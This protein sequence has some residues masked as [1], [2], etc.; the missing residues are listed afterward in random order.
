MFFASSQITIAAMKY[1]FIIFLMYALTY[2]SALTF[3]YTLLILYAYFFLLFK[4]LLLCHVPAGIPP[5]S[6]IPIQNA[7]FFYYK[8]FQ[9]TRKHLFL[10]LPGSHIFFS[11][12]FLSSWM[13]KSFPHKNCHTD[14][15]DGSYFLPALFLLT[16]VGNL[17]LRIG[18]PDHYG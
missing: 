17:C 1:I 7:F 5:V 10:H 8:T 4:P 16:S 11:I 13:Q 18:S 9:Y 14:I 2:W 12:F 15:P 3:C 6:C